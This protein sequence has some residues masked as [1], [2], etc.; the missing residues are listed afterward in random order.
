MLTD[1]MLS[2]R[3]QIT[4]LYSN[5][6]IDKYI[7]TA[8]DVA[9]YA[10]KQRRVIRR[11]KRKKGDKSPLKPSYPM[12]PWLI[13]LIQDKCKEY[14]SYFKMKNSKTVCISIETIE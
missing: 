8:I 1:K 4:T 3:W 14:T 5:H 2:A 9:K 6:K 10:N 11:L 13:D 12:S 7:V